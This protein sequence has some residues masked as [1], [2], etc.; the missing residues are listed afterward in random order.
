[1]GGVVPGKRFNISEMALRIE[2]DIETQD[3]RYVAWKPATG[4]KLTKSGAVSG[5]RTGMQSYVDIC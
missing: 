4:P 1:M 2:K 5:M 3:E